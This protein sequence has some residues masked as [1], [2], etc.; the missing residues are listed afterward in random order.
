MDRPQIHATVD[1]DR[2]GSKH[3][4]LCVPYSYKERGAWN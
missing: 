3:G 4:H 1:F 2:A